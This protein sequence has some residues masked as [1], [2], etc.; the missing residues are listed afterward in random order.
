M[1]T[2]IVR[3]ADRD[4]RDLRAWAAVCV[5]LVCALTMSISL[6]AAGGP[7]AARDRQILLMHAD[8]TYE[9]GYMFYS[10]PPDW[11]SFAEMYEGTVQVRSIVLDLSGYTFDPNWIDAYLWTDGGGRPGLVLAVV[12]GV[13]CNNV[14]DPPDF[15]RNSI[16]LPEPFGVTG[17][18]WVGFWQGG[19]VEYWIG[20][21]LDGPGGDSPMVKIPTGAGFPTGWQSVDLVWGPTAALGIGAEVDLPTPVE[22]ATWGSIKGLYR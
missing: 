18:W 13:H 15:G 8:G 5:G 6:A 4:G 1:K 14:P 17:T 2:I 3:L 9:N 11:G 7:G 19:W 22:S 12:T 21:D 16:E 10:P 20:A